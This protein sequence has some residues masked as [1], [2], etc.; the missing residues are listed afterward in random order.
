MRLIAE[1]QVVKNIC[2]IIHEPNGS[3]A[4][5]GKQGPVLLKHS[6]NFYIQLFQLVLIRC[7]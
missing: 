1:M 2:A 6:H 7:W 4:I 3:A 5:G